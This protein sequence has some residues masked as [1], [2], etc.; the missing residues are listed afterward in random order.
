MNLCKVFSISVLPL[1]ILD[2]LLMTLEDPF[3]KQLIEATF[4]SFLG[5]L[6]IYMCCKLA[7]YFK[8][9]ERREKDFQIQLEDLNQGIFKKR[10]LRFTVGRYGYYLVVKFSGIMQETSVTMSQDS[11]NTDFYYQQRTANKVKTGKKGVANEE[12]A[13]A[14]DE[15]ELEGEEDYVEEEDAN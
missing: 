6:L 14:D 13:F 8:L 4:L 1:L 10:G 12:I 9:Q 2:L 3:Q 7:N 5:I 11:I 15:G